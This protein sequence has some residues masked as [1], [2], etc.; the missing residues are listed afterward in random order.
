MKRH[1]LHFNVEDSFKKLKNLN[2][3]FANLKN[4]VEAYQSV[5]LNQV[6]VEKLF[7]K[8]SKESQSKYNLL[9]NVLETD[10]NNSTLYD[11]YNAF[12]NYSSTIRE[13]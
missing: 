10:V 2:D 9:L 12:T 3:T 13:Q 5:K 11:V 6:D 8:F 1:T 4:T 7:R